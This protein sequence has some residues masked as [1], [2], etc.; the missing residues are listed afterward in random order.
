ML[1]SPHVT[2][3]TCKRMRRENSKR[4]PP[5]KK[6]TEKFPEQVTVETLTGETSGAQ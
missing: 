2:V 5:K 1:A 6:G 4:T 3:S